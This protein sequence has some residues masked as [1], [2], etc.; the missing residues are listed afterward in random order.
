MCLQ[1]N[2][3]N[4]WSTEKNNKMYWSKIKEHVFHSLCTNKEQ[5]TIAAGNWGKRPSCY[6][7][8]VLGFC[9][10]TLRLSPQVP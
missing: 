3:V 5:P 6:F 4:N 8:N 9:M 1:V 2:N 10:S 7:L